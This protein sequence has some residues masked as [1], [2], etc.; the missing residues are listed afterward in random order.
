MS[1][2]KALLSASGVLK[3]RTS[4]SG[5]LKKSAATE[6]ATSSGVRKKSTATE[7]ATSSS[8]ATERA[9]TDHVFRLPLTGIPSPST[10]T[11]RASD[12]GDGFLLGD[13]DLEKI[14]ALLLWMA[15]D[16]QSNIH[17]DDI[18]IAALDTIITL[19]MNHAIGT[20]HTASVAKLAELIDIMML[21]KD[22]S[23]KDANATLTFMRR[24]A[25]VREQVRADNA[26]ERV[27]LNEDEVSLCYQKFGRILLTEDLLA[28]QKKDKRYCLR[29]NF[30][31]DTQLSTFQRSFTDNMLRKFLGDKRVAFLIWQQGLPRIA[32][33]PLVY[34]RRRHATEQPDMGMLQSGLAECLQWYCCLANNIVLHQ[35][36]EGFDT[37]LS[38]SSLDK[39]ERRR[40]QTGREAL[41]K[42]RDALRLGA[43]LAK[44][45]DT[46]KRSYD[47]MDDTEQQTLE[48]YET[49][50]AKRAKQALSTSKMKPF[51][52]NL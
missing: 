41:Q 46:N 20:L 7:R 21:H 42:A 45:R 22:G 3:K 28:H 24:L 4:A 2:V 26:T 44:Q 29:N 12:V 43:T 19:P 11:E 36:Q 52:C 49:G 35:T 34:R 50:R 15:Q 51:R 13:D 32:D 9:S 10:A 27:E 18:H 40:Q 31:G 33:S 23:P 30:V 37:Q 6:R 38:A 8:T 48:D 1:A 14:V 17:M 25:K 16:F 47:E 39:Q 5:I